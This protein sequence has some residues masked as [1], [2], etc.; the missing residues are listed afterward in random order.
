MPDR[1]DDLAPLLGKQL[2]TL[3]RQPENTEVRKAAWGTAMRLG[4]FEQAAALDAPISAAERR[5]MEGDIIALYIRYGIVDRNTLRGPERFLRLDKALT[6]T[7]P[8]AA[9]FFAGK[10]L[11]SEDQRRLTDRLSALASR[12]RA[13]D[14]V[15]LYE[16][17]R[18]R[19][20]PVPLWAERDIAGSYLEL[21]LPQE[22]LSRYR[23]VVAANPDDFDANL[24]LFYALVE[25]EQLDACLLYTSRCV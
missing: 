12:R 4:L 7:D 15:K 21:R 19:D 9:E 25:T 2:A 18:Q 16:T 6:A 1:N 22:A 8:L 17:L 14:A 10:T 13:A 20:I 11:D 3:K 23:Q 5:A 24:G